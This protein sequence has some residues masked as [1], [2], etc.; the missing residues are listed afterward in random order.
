M[1]VRPKFKFK[2]MMDDDLHVPILSHQDEKNEI[3]G[4][5]KE[6]KMMADLRTL[7]V[8]ICLTVAD[9]VL[10]VIL[11]DKYTDRYSQYLNQGTAGVYCIVSTTIIL[12]RM[13]LGDKKP[14]FGNTRNWVLISIGLLNGK[15][16]FG[17][18]YNTTTTTTSTTGTANFFMATSQA[19]T[20]GI[21]QSLLYQL[22]I[23]LVLAL[24]WLFVGKLCSKIAIAGASL[25]ILGTYITI[26]CR[27]NHT[28]THTHTHTQV[29]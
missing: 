25:I 8:L 15:I 18:L 23:P 5:E 20:P 1:Y 6:V 4:D 13:F 22:T 19:H 14:D 21:T 28:H 24:S 3:N 16:F 7:L 11:F 26:Q 10:V 17:L 29:L 12:G 2:K 27:E 9:G